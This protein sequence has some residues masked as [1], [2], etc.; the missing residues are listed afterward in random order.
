VIG[1][2]INVHRELGPGLVEG[3]YETSLCE[4]LADA[5]LAFAPARAKPKRLRFGVGRRQRRLPVTYKGRALGGYYQ[6]DIVIDD[7]LVL[8]VKAVHQFHPVYAAQLMTNLRIGDFPL[9]LLM[10]FNTDLMKNGI[11]RLLNPA[12]P[13]RPVP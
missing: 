5:G 12:A 11:T 6:L 4:E 3:L 8:E 7:A 10:N 9:G 13:S 1:C 2:A